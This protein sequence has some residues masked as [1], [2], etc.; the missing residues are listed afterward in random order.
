MTIIR[1]DTGTLLLTISRASELLSVHP[2]T[3]RRWIR[4]GQLSAVRLPSGGVRVPASEI[5]AIAD[6]RGTSPT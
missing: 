1:A 3:L 6:R 2:G 4:K 5:S